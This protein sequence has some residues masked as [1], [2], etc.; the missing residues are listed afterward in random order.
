MIRPLLKD[1]IK[2]TVK[3]VNNTILSNLKTNYQDELVQKNKLSW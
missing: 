1:V 2:A 3:L